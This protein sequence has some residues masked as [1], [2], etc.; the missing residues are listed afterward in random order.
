MRLYAFDCSYRDLPE[1]YDFVNSCYWNPSFQR[2][3]PCTLLSD[4]DCQQGVPLG[5]L[6]FYASVMLLIN[7]LQSTFNQGVYNIE[8]DHKPNYV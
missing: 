2:F 4:E 7:R 8:R 1:L 3:G 6:L 5:P